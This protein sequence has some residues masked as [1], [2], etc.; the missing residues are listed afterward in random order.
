MSRVVTSD[1]YYITSG[2]RIPVMWTAPEVEKITHI[3]V[4]NGSLHV[5]GVRCVSG[6][7]LSC[8]R[9]YCRGST[10]PAVMCGAME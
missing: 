5:S 8:Y 2:G 6:S 9:P 1:P 4:Y 7:L 3:T 10:V